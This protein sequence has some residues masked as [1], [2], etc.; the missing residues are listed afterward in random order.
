MHGLFA[1]EARADYALAGAAKPPGCRMIRSG[2]M[3][4]LIIHE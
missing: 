4:D 3:P 2:S 1:V